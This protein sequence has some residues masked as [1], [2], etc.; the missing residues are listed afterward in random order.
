MEVPDQ[1]GDTPTLKP[2]KVAVVRDPSED[3][4]VPDPTYA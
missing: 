3:P 1:I 4:A 2:E